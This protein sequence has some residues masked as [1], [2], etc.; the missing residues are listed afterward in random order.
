MVVPA[1]AVPVKFDGE[2]T[3]T[4]TRVANE[5][6][7]TLSSTPW[8]R[9]EERWNEMQVGRQGSYS[10]ERLESLENYCNSTSQTRVMFVCLLTPLP[11]LMTASLLEC[12]PLR[13]PPDGWA[14][15]WVFWVRFS[16]MVCSLVF[17]GIDAFNQF[18]PNFGLTSKRRMIV[19]LGTTVGYVGICLVVAATNI[20]GFPILFIWQGGGLAVGIFIPIMFLVLFGAAPFTSS[21]PFRPHIQRYVRLFLAYMSLGAV[22]PL[23]EL[24]Y[25]F[26]P[27]IYKS[28]IF[29]VL[30]VWKFGAKHFIMLASRELEDFIPVVVALTVDFFSAMFVSV[31]ISS[32]G[33]TYLSVLIIAADIGQIML[34]FREVRD[35]SKT[36]LTLLESAGERYAVQGE[37]ANYSTPNTTYLLSQILAV[38]R[39][40]AAFNIVS[41]KRTRLWAY[42]PHRITSEQHDRLIVLEASAVYGPRGLISRTRRRSSQ[43]RRQSRRLLLNWQLAK[44]TSIAPAPLNRLWSKGPSCAN[45]IQSVEGVQSRELVAQGLQLQFHCEYLALVEYVECVVPLVFATNKLILKELPNAVYYPG[46]ASKWGVTALANVFLYAA[47]DICSLFLLNHFLK[48]KFVFSPLYQ[49]AFALESSMHFVQGVLFIEIV[50]LLQYELMHLDTNSSTFSLLITA[51]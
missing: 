21:S 50:G 30:P 17:F 23:Y 16:I 2:L 22:F 31:C 3:T 51:L 14:A 10:V 33:P 24:L 8:R 12:L 38:T 11:G 18:V 39:N 35:N 43:A 1:D 13:S 5:I 29:I 49:L 15:N 7:R 25:E 9:L 46:G 4:Q 45:G 27:D 44:P 47:L 6:R 34:E 36:L 26:V 48:R 28:G 42:L 32:S 20:M 41:L 37:T 19:S 40:P